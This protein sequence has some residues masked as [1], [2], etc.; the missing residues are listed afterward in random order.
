MRVSKRKVQDLAARGIAVRSGRGTYNL[1]ES[2][3]NYA[4]HMR[5][6]AAGRGG[7]DGALDLATERARLAKQQAD[8]VELKNAS[9]RNELVAVSAVEAEWSEI[10]RAARVRMLSVVGRLRQLRPHWSAADFDAL[11]REIREALTELSNGTG[12]SATE[13]G[14]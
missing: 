3:G 14:G 9:L 6:V 4:D 8:N 1:A 11:D 12:A 13:E 2:V 5:M 10:V 7:E